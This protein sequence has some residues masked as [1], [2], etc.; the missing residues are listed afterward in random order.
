MRILIRARKE[1]CREGAASQDDSGASTPTSKSG[2]GPFGGHPAS[3]PLFQVE[4]LGGGVIH[5]IYQVF[6][7][8]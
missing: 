2:A 4:G 3:L 1:R 8:A 7:L 6:L 5:P